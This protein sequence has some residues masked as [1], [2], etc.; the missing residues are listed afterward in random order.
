[1]GGFATHLPGKQ[2]RAKLRINSTHLVT[3]PRVEQVT[4]IPCSLVG[5]RESCPVE[6]EDYN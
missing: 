2:Q 6:T 1:M 5:R 3:G 4:N